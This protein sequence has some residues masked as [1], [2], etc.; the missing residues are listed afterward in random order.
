MG[1]KTQPGQ[2]DCY[3]ALEPDE[4]FFVLKATDVSAPLAVFLWAELYRERKQRAGQWNA[5]AV[6]RYCEAHLIGNQMYEWRAKKAREL[7]K[8]IPFSVASPLTTMGFPDPEQLAQGPVTVRGRAVKLPARQNFGAGSL[9]A[10]MLERMGEPLGMQSE[11]PDGDVTIGDAIDAE[12]PPP[13]GLAPV[14]GTPMST[15]WKDE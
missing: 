3:A 5:K 14:G 13:D 7:D 12:F 2:F 8:P 9:A 15:P 6:D 4:P 11:P 1:T 10:G